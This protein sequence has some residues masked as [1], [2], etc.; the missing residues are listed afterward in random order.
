MLDWRWDLALEN[1]DMIDF[2]V[3]FDWGRWLPKNEF[4][5]TNI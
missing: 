3:F 5:K 1:F 2:S 4:L